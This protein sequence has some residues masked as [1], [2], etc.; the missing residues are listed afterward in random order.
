MCDVYDSNPPIAEEWRKAKKEHKCYA[1]REIIRIGDRYHFI[2]QK[3]DEFFTV[4][5]CARCWTMGEAIL[6]AGSDSWQY[7]LACGVSW[8]EAFGQEPPDEIAR[9]AFITP[10]E[11]QKE[12]VRGDS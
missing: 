6:E 3:D 12:L 1:C 7:D 4:K 5:H 2:A 8:Q 11:A 9:L 10:G